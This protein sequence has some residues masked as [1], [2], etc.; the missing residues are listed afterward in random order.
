MKSGD[1]SRRGPGSDRSFAGDRVIAVDRPILNRA[2][3]IYAWKCVVLA[4]DTRSRGVGPAS[5]ADRS[6]AGSGRGKRAA[7]HGLQTRPPDIDRT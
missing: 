7:S 6:A 4:E 3:S 5:L 2:P 1:W